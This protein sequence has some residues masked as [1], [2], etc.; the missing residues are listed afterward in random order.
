VFERKRAEARRGRRRRARGE[1]QVDHRIRGPV[2][3]WYPRSEQASVDIELTKARPRHLCGDKLYIG[4]L[5]VVDEG[6]VRVVHDGTNNKATYTSSYP[7]ELRYPGA[8]ELN[9]V[10]TELRDQDVNSPSRSATPARR[11]EKRRYAATIGATK[12]AISMRAVWVNAGTYGMTSSCFWALRGGGADPLGPL[13]IS[14]RPIEALCTRTTLLWS[15][16][17][18]SRK[19]C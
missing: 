19:P 12:A 8:V 15:R 16:R 14:P 5:G 4:A 2:K 17:C 18:R 10:L 13:L 1:Q 7:P 6:V 11:T 9:T 3:A